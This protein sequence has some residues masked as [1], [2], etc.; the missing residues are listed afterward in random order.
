MRQD[1]DL[2]TLSATD[3][4]NFLSCRHRTALEM[5]RSPRQ[6]P[7]AEVGRSAARDPLPARPRAREGLRRVAPNR[8]GDDRRPH[9]REGARTRRWRRTRRDAVA[10]P[11]SSSRRLARRP[12]V[13]PAGRAAAG[14][15]AERARPWSYEVADTKLARE[16]RAGT[17][18]QLGL[19]SELLGAAQGARPERF[20]VVTPDP[21]PDPRRTASTTTPRTSGWSARSWK[22]FVAQD[23]DVVAAAHYPEP[24]E[25]CDVC[26]WSAAATQK[27]RAD[28]HL[29][30]V[31]GI[32]R[33][34]R[35]ELES[36]GV[37][38]LA[39][40]ADAAAAAAASSRRAARVETYVRVREQA[41]VQ[42]ESRGNS[43]SV[44]ELRPISS[45]GRRSEPAAGAS[46]GDVFLD[47]EG[48]PF[49]GD[50]GREYL[51][52]S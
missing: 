27:R 29:S 17:I 7:A 43:R 37:A 23:D 51:F 48:D 8:G 44:H 11:R 2:L 24:V 47:L 12:L 26:P 41:R 38:T 50:G 15:D 5:A 39:A 20:H 33:L 42:F 4:S 13:R 31:A 32:S 30:L 28:D 6:A 35:R 34:Q 36:R 10:A 49:A 3:L 1:V 22:A 40:L 21:T 52:G 16:T 46:P 9:R 18:L 19:Y 14:G 45:E 25:H